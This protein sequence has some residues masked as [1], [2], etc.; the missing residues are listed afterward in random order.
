MT[1]N[2]VAHPVLISLANLLMDFKSKAT[3]HAFMLLALLP[4]PKF[5]EKS[6]EIRGVLESRLIHECLDFVLKPLKTAA[7]VGVIMSDPWHGQR[8]CYTPIAAYIMD[9]MEAVVIAGVAGK[10]SP[11]TTAS[12]KQFGDAFLHPPRTAALTLSQ[13]AAL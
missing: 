1:G 9:Y 10:T 2:R 12:Y 8:Y 13:L 4:V 11:V 7:A 5:I 3:N 6:R